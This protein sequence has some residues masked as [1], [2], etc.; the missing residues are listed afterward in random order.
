MKK[1]NGRAV[2][3]DGVIGL[4][5]LEGN[6]LNCNR[7]NA[8]TITVFFPGGSDRRHGFSPWVGKNPWRR[9]W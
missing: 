9:A 4:R 6:V 1:Q 8:D 2:S 7:R 3:T 5:R